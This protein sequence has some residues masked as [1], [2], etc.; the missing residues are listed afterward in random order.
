MEICCWKERN[1]EERAKATTGS[2][3][4]GSKVDRGNRWKDTKAAE[5]C[6]TYADARRRGILRQRKK[7]QHQERK[8][9]ARTDMEICCWKERN[10]AEKARAT[11]GSTGNREKQS[12]QV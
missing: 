4:A 3:A 6:R 8:Q 1:W 9:E 12:R 7:R 11:T 10:W 2:K 5:K